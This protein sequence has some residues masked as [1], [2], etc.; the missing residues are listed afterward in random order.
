MAARGAL[1]TLV[2]VV[3]LATSARG[4]GMWVLWEESN[5]MRTFVRTPANR[6]RSIHTRIEDC[7]KAI[8]AEWEKLLAA[9]PTPDSGFDRLG[10]TSAVMMMTYGSH[11]LYRDVHLSARY[12]AT[13]VLNRR[14]VERRRLLGWN[15]LV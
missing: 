2:C 14:R 13:A 11:H 9:R 7:I 15:H 3:A 4:A 8:D 10:P 5:E 12:R 1:L 6:V